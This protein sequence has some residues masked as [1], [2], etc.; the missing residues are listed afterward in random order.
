MQW[1]GMVES[2]KG[3]KLLRKGVCEAVL[4]WTAANSDGNIVILFD[5]EGIYIKYTFIVYRLCFK[6]SIIKL[7]CNVMYLFP[8][9]GGSHIQHEELLLLYTILEK[10]M[11]LLPRTPLS[12]CV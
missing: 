3:G 1:E 11:I 9:G 4:K 2:A 8:L 7:I 12:S 5:S 10:V 6:I